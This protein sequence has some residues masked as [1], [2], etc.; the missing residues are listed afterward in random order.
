MRNTFAKVITE[1]AKIDEKI[2]LLSG[3]IGNKM[4]DDFKKVDSKRFINCGIAEANMMSVA[5]GLALT[6]M[7]PFIYTIAPFTTSRCLEQV[8][9]GAAYHDT[10]ITIIGTG[11]GLSYA[12]LG[13]THHSLEDMSIISSIPNMRVLAPCDSIELANQ[14]KEIINLRGPSYI[15]IGKKGEPN[16]FDHN[17]VTQI[18]KAEI[19]KDGHDFLIV[20]IGPILSEALKASE[21]LEKHHSISTC[22][23]SLGGI[24]PLDNSFLEEMAKRNFKYWFSLEEH[25][26]KGGLGSEVNNWIINSEKLGNIKIKNIC[27]PKEF[28][29][30]L[31]DQSY[32]RDVLKLNSKGI[33]ETILNQ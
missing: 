13:P 27:T 22:I 3:D 15:R 11:S 9:I 21:Y 26:L 33:I 7:K 20:G 31:G 10:H 24:S 32:I 5:S 16:L 6:G 29:H 28:I 1:L 4:F 12:E 8:K 23:A 19:I 2:V 30:R 17:K 14:L 18:G 25:G